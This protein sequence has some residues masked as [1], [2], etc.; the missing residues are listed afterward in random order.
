[1]AELIDDHAW[2]A[3]NPSGVSPAKRQPHGDRPCEY[4]NCRRPKAEH[5]V[6]AVDWR[7]YK[8]CPVCAAPMGEPCFS[9]TGST[10]EPAEKPHGGRSLRASYARGGDRG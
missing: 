3:P 9:L 5:G 1:M 6:V 10:E 2:R 8:K 4:L 7:R